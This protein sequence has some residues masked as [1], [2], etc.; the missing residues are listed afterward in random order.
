MA[1]EPEPRDMCGITKEQR[2]RYVELFNGELRETRATGVPTI[3]MTRCSQL[4]NHKSCSQFSLTGGLKAYHYR[5]K[6]VDDV[7]SLE[8]GGYIL[9]LDRRPRYLIITRGIHPF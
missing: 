9:A 5:R 2:F 3:L 4:S 6:A 7:V 8:R 1:V